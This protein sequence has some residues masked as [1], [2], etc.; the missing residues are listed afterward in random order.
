[1]PMQ[2]DRQ[3]SF[4]RGMNDSAAPTEYRPDEVELLQ[5]CRVSLDGRTA[6]RRNGTRRTHDAALNSAAQCYGLIEFTTTAGAQQL[7]TFMGTKMYTSTDEG[8]TWTEQATGLTAAAWSCVIM[9]E[10]STNVLCCANGGT[11]SYQ[12]D[13][14]TWAVIA[15]IP[16]DVKY[17]AVWNDRLAAA[18]HDGV[19]I[20]VSKVG[21]IDTWANPDGFTLRF[22]THDGDTDITGIFPL[23]TIMLVWKRSSLGYTEGFGF[24]TVEVEAGARGISRS[25]GC[26]APRTIKACG[27]M[28]VAWLSER[29]IEYYEV[30]GRVTLVTRALQATID[31]VAWNTIVTDPRGPTALWWPSKHEYWCGLP[32]ATNNNDYV[33]VYRPPVDDQPPSLW[34]FKHTAANDDTLYLDSGGYLTH[35]ANPDQDQG[36]IDV[37]GYLETTSGLG[38]Y[39]TIDASGYLDFSSGQSDHATLAV[40]DIGTNISHPIGGGYSGFVR[41]IEFGDTDD[42]TRTGTTSGDDIAMRLITRPFVFGDEMRTQKAKRIRV[43]SNQDEEATVTMRVLADGVA[44]TNHSVTFPVAVGSRPVTEKARVGSKAFAHSVEITSTDAVDI[45]AVELAATLLAE[46]W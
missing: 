23:G 38:Q 30:G 6:R 42:R 31:D 46:P 4:A 45:S 25:V 1:M 35:S 2:V 37:Q 22:A 34:V 21:D 3:T 16:D 36:E 12:W 24:N 27:D 5:N 10:G 28:G 9:R 18:G 8:V 39:M 17:L 32:V 43:S 15:N 14:T 19:E 40:A 11:S 13:G 41:E 29:G 33:I 7:V 26:I 20:A 44:Q